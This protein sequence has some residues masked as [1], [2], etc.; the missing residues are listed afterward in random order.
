MAE[1]SNNAE[2]LLL[3]FNIYNITPEQYNLWLLSKPQTTQRG[4]FRLAL[5]ELLNVST[6]DYVEDY[7][8][9]YVE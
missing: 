9:D 3:W 7:V 5:E 2:K 1:L 6:C 4:I 8:D